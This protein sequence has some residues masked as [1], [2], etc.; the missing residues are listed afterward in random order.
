MTLSLRQQ[1]AALA[2]LGALTAGTIAA[3]GASALS[4]AVGAADGLVAQRELQRAQMEA[5]MAHD[6]LRSDVMAGLFAHASGDSAG[7]DAARADAAETARTLRASLE[8][9][10]RGSDGAVARAAIAA[11]PDVDAYAVSAEAVFAAPQD[12]EARAAF[13]GRFETLVTELDALG[14]AIA[15]DTAIADAQ[16]AAVATARSRLIGLAVAGIALLAVGSAAIAA[17]VVRDVRLVADRAEQLRSMCITNLGNASTALARGDIGFRLEYGTPLLELDRDD[18]IGQLAA[19]VDG[20][21][22]QSVATIHAFEAARRSIQSVT[23]E[24]GGLIEATRDGRLDARGDAAQF[25][26][27]WQTLVADMNTA[28]DAAVTPLAEAAQVLDRVSQRDL[29]A[30]MSGRYRGDHA[31][32]QSALNGALDTLGGTLADV[33]D[34]GENVRRASREIAGA[35]QSLADR[36]SQQAGTLEEI[37]SSLSELAS[38]AELNAEG[39]STA[40]GL[41]V[42]ARS[43]ADAGGDGVARLTEAMQAIRDSAH[44]TRRVLA[45]I[46]EIAFQT[47][48]L[49]LNA[50]VEAAR[51]GEAGRGFAV[52]ADEVRNLALR[53]AREA[54]ATSALTEQ[55]VASAE[56][57]AAASEAVAASL[58]GIR[59]GVE[60][61]S[62]VIGE[63]RDGSAR[64]RAGVTELLAG[65]N[66]LSNATQ[67]SAAGAEQSAA[68]AQDLA[69]SADHV[70]SLVGAF[71]LEARRAARTARATDRASV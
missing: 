42:D 8:K 3:V 59:R 53:S 32:V 29:T 16:R 69:T 60:R 31:R 4:E 64:Q 50:A 70:Q 18:E 10:R 55:S 41:A 61:V 9:V 49:A 37:S 35:A 47:N 45:T 27:V 58:D 26:G 65:V 71:Q 22:L 51:A 43:S 12:A 25:E 36:T 5:D 24:I 13:E 48:L 21:I 63:I 7:V 30:R 66:I 68:T 17:S 34:S 44:E 57:G 23:R 28:L 46:N 40:H 33:R 15:S 1:L 54:R 20:I 56:R 39:A 6:A 62:E 2:L 67:D 38:V 11:A 14:D 52:V 19:T